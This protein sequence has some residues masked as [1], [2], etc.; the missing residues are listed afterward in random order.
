MKSTQYK[1]F[2]QKKKKKKGTKEIDRM[3]R[4]QERGKWQRGDEE[5]GWKEFKKK[6]VCDREKRKVEKR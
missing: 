5:K 3:R 6:N 2:P 4:R 1:Q